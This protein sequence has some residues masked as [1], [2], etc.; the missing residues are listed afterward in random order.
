[1]KWFMISL[2]LLVAGPA[3]GQVAPECTDATT[4][5]PVFT[6][7]QLKMTGLEANLRFCTPQFDADGDPIPETGAIASCSVELDGVVQT[8]SVTGPGTIFSATVTG[9]NPGHQIRAWC[10]TVEGED[11]EVW[12]SDLCFPA[13][14]PKKPHPRIN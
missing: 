7:C 11:G 10:T 4:E 8:F 14:Q 5:P 1:M 3:L 9:K 13:R 12:L 6:G 2:A